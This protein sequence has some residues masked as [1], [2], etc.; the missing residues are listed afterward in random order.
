MTKPCE[1][2]LATFL[3]YCPLHIHMEV[4]GVNLGWVG[5]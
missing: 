3:V 5:Y 4:L 1:A 2:T